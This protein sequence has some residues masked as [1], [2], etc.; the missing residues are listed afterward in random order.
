MSSKG[1][2][3][4]QII[5]AIVALPLLRIQDW[6][7][8]PVPHYLQLETSI[9]ENSSILTVRFLNLHC[10]QAPNCL[11]ASIFFLPSSENFFLLF[12]LWS[13]LALKVLR[14]EVGGPR[15]F[16]VGR[17]AIS[18]DMWLGREWVDGFWCLFPPDDKFT[19]IFR[20]ELV[21]SDASSKRWSLFC[22]MKSLSE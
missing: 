14:R 3:R 9:F 20:D 19:D 21:I 17:E 5:V 1:D 15:R 10:T 18:W 12:L 11:T 22:R 16:F 2:S 6:Q 4:V 8:W 7:G 13:S